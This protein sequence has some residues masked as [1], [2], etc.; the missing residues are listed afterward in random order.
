MRPSRRV[1][2][3]PEHFLRL[4][5]SSNQRPTWSTPIETMNHGNA[6]RRGRA[7]SALHP[8]RIIQRSADAIS[9]C[10]IW[11]AV[12]FLELHR[13]PI[14]MPRH[15]APALRAEV[16]AEVGLLLRAHDARIISVQLK[17]PEFELIAAG[18]KFHGDPV[19]GRDLVSD[20]FSFRERVAFLGD[21]GVEGCGRG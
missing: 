11:K 21:N 8:A 20:T 18:I 9:I 17:T 14:P 6:V 10:T 2:G 3:S 7:H 1:N 4:R 16:D 15:N 19:L 12:Q 5:E 13:L